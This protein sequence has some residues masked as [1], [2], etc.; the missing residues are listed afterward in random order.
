MKL[1]AGEP[2]SDRNLCFSL[3][4]ASSLGSTTPF[5][6]RA[7][8]ASTAVEPESVPGFLP[9]LRL[10]RSKEAPPSP[11][12]VRPSKTPRTEPG[13][14]PLP[15]GKKRTGTDWKERLIKDKQGS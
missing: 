3:R 2:R 14:A 11:P 1:A 15:S 10:R 8:K 5:S 6:R 4:R 9:R 7:R 12:S 13:S